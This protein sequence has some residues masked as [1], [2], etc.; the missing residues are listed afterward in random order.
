MLRFH[1]SLELLART[2]KSR[3]YLSN[4]NPSAVQS[5]TDGVVTIHHFAESG[6]MELM[7]ILRKLLLSSPE[8]II[9][10]SQ[11]HSDYALSSVLN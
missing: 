9:P 2:T 10:V 5:P 4:Q 8:R 3:F 1:R 6:V 11:T 7:F